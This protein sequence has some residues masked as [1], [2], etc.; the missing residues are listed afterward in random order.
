M[1]EFLKFSNGEK[2]NIVRENVST[3]ERTFSGSSELLQ[4]I[5]E[6]QRNVLKK[7]F[8]AFEINGFEVQPDGSFHFKGGTGYDVVSREIFG[9]KVPVSELF[10]SFLDVKSKD[11]EQA[12]QNFNYRYKVYENDLAKIESLDFKTVNVNTELNASDFM[13]KGEYIIKQNENIIGKVNN[14]G[15]K[16]KFDFPTERLDSYSFPKIIAELSEKDFSVEINSITEKY[17]YN[18]EN[19]NLSIVKDKGDQ[20]SGD[21]RPI[22]WETREDINNMRLSME[23]IK[24]LESFNYIRKGDTV[25]V[26]LG[27]KVSESKD[28]FKEVE[29]F[30]L[31]DE[32]RNI[33]FENREYKSEDKFEM[34][35]PIVIKEIYFLNDN[36]AF[37]KS[38]DNEVEKFKQKYIVSEN[39]ETIKVKVDNQEEIN[40][41]ADAMEMYEDI[42]LENNISRNFEVDNMK[43]AVALAENLWPETYF[44][45]KEGNTLYRDE[46]DLVFNSGKNLSLG[47]MFECYKAI[48]ALQNEDYPYPVMIVS[49]ERT[50]TEDLALIEDEKQNFVFTVD[51][52]ADEV[53]NEAQ[54]L[55]KYLDIPT[56]RIEN[57]DGTKSAVVFK[58]DFL[59]KENL[60]NF[61]KENDIHKKLK[62]IPEVKIVSGNISTEMK[63]GKLNEDPKR[64]NSNNKQREI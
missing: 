55:I 51:K 22:L 34:Y 5:A 36:E 16:I 38:I 52:I 57:G 3:G 42:F 28:F 59:N 4:Q 23:G 45:D 60:E 17:N 56:F 47:E 8:N 9:S 37:K 31:K 21:T 46:D 26:E 25:S 61:I 15:E 13:D 6:F 18:K 24:N 44:N 43:V 19:G 32:N 11:T 35:E 62:S 27:G 54:K 39:E 41:F 40:D 53:I 20:Y 14:D 63:N 7:D 29:K 58:E 12:K 10:D 33:V 30:Q 1:N 2:I 48:D 49:N 64:D 50:F